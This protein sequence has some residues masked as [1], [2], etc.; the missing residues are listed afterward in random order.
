MELIPNL[1]RTEYL[2]L[3]VEVN[4][5]V[6]K[7]RLGTIGLNPVK[8]ID[9]FVGE[10]KKGSKRLRNI[11]SGRGSRKYKLFTFDSI[12]SVKTLWEQ[13]GLQQDEKLLAIGVSLWRLNFLEIE[14]RQFIFKLNQG[15]IHGNNVIS[16]FAGVDRKCTFCRINSISTL[17]VR[18]GRD[19]LDIEIAADNNNLADEGRLHIFWECDTVQNC[20][21]NV[22]R[23]LWNT[24]R[25]TKKNVLMGSLARSSEAAQLYQIS[26]MFIRYKIWNYKL[27]GVKPRIGTIANETHELLQRIC[28]KPN[29]RGILPQVRQIY[30]EEED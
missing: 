3:R 25:I 30:E 26:N 4:W 15:L 17:R 5:V 22:H 6:R 14:F 23:L 7:Y 24:N 8:S 20:L 27:A 19:P 28:K 18:L 9:Q 13:L 12:R 16:H 11:M 29:W 21:L 2:R 10:I 1:S